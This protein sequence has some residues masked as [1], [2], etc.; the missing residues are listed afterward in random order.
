MA[1]EYHERA[2]AIYLKLYGEEHADTAWSLNNLGY[3][4]RG[5]GDYA[6]ALECD[7]RALA[8]RLKLFGEEHADT[9]HSLN[10]LGVDYRALGDY[11]KAAECDKR[12]IAIR[13]K[14]LSG[15]EIYET[16]I[17]LNNLGVDFRSLGDY[18]KAVEYDEQALAVLSKLYGES[19]RSIAMSLSNL[20]VDYYRLG[21]YEQ[22]E[23]YHE[24]SLA[25]KQKLLGTEHPSTARALVNMGIFYTDTGDYAKAEEYIKRALIIQM[26]LFGRDGEDIAQSFY[27]LGKLFNNMQLKASAVFC[28][29]QAVNIVQLAKKRIS[30][31]DKD[32]Q[33][34]F[35]HFNEYLYQG[36]ADL[37]AEQGRILE[38]Q[39]VLAMLD[40]K[41]FF[42]F[43]GAGVMAAEQVAQVPYT[44]REKEYADLLD[45][46]AQIKNN[47]DLASREFESLIVDLKN[48]LKERVVDV[49]REVVVSHPELEQRHA[50]RLREI[51]EQQLQLELYREKEELVKKMKNTS[52]DEWDSSDD[53]KR[54][55][56]IRSDL[57]LASREF[58]S[59]IGD[60]KNELKSDADPKY[61]EEFAGMKLNAAP[62]LQDTLRKMGNGAVLLN[63]VPSETR[64]AIMLTT[65]ATQIHFEFAISREE[66]LEKISTFRKCLTQQRSDI[67]PVAK[68][69][70]RILL[71]PAEKFLKDAKAHTLMFNLCGPLRY[72]PMAALHDGKE[73]LAQKYAI[74]TYTEATIDLLSKPD[75]REWQV[76]AFGVT[77]EHPGF[78]KLSAVEGELKSIVREE[79]VAESDNGI[80]PGRIMLNEKFTKSAFINALDRDAPVVHVASH[81]QYESGTA[82]NSFL[83]L[84]DGKH[85]TL[86]EISNESFSFGK[87]DQLTLSACETAMGT[88]KGAGREM[89]GF[90]LLVH[91]KGAKSILATL[92]SVAD[93]STGIFMPRYYELLQKDGMTKAEAL[94]QAQT[95][96]IK[97]TA[98][99]VVA[100]K[101]EKSGTVKGDGDEP[102]PT[103]FPGYS[104]PYYWAP[105]VLMGNW[106]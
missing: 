15:E 68:E 94:R 77:K 44:K 86:D 89:E 8:I 45:E 66:L 14:I 7:E 92:W 101:N 34:S 56:E 27:N 50:D 22:A 61:L 47:L 64:V 40:E 2:L 59:F 29:K 106:L 20:G 28:M 104:H 26:K 90:A 30:K 17:S 31:E 99:P 39:Q 93:A 100:G 76:A 80:I 19:H 53:A 98:K 16:A 67:L 49:E 97:S 91:M 57:D 3:D 65:P 5:L 51:K 72:I 41:E 12:A 1:K 95:E 43:I 88:G 73:W 82:G 38:A 84:G 11:I 83:L 81:F 62:A 4:Y 42:D 103:F 102:T 69:L 6:K 25:I 9:V 70:Y 55:A 71:S 23:K 18:A 32:L 60:L 52:E 24:R 33:E 36:L 78:E 58:E 75:V 10:N 21:D 79:G 105:F 87:V 35:L 74:V 85:L 37:L 96:F 13:L 46:I 54:L 48:K 63:I